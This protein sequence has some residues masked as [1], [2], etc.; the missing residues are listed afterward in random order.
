M[1]DLFDQKQLDYKHIVKR[2]RG[3]ISTLERKGRHLG[4]QYPTDAQI[5]A[6]AIEYL[7]THRVIQH[8]PVALEQAKSML[9]KTEAERRHWKVSFYLLSGFIICTS[10]VLVSYLLK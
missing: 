7:L 6:D 2:L 5:A 1:T 8:N 3:R 10:L 4:K 9:K